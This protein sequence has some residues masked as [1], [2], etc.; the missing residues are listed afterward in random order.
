MPRPRL[1]L[2]D[3]FGFLFRAFHA[4]ARSGAP[5]MRTSSGIPTEIVF[6]FNVMLKQLRTVHQPGWLAPDAYPF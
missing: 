1:F 2:I 5:P 4:R 6:I 3:T